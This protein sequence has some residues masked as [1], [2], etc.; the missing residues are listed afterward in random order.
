MEKYL[1]PFREFATLLRDTFQACHIHQVR[2]ML[3]GEGVGVTISNL[4]KV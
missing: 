3:Q 1:P 4:G 2:A